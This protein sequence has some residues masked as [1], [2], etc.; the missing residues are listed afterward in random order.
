MPAWFRRPTVVPRPGASVA[1]HG[2]VPKTLLELGIARKSRALQSAA[3]QQPF[4]LDRALAQL[5][6]APK[7]T[8][9]GVEIGSLRF[10]QFQ[11]A[12]FP[13]PKPGTG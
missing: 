8:Q 2:R 9:A 1:D 12:E 13:F 11:K 5:P 6:Q 10:E 3:Q 4:D 7:I